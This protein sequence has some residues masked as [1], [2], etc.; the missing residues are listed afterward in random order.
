[1]LLDRSQ[2]TFVVVVFISTSSRWPMKKRQIKTMNHQKC[3]E[4]FSSRTGD[5]S[6]V[7]LNDERR[8]ITIC[9]SGIDKLVKRVLFFCGISLQNIFLAFSI[10]VSETFF[11]FQRGIDDLFVFVRDFLTSQRARGC[12]DN[13]HGHHTSMKWLQKLSSSAS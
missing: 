4:R 8:F 12:F 11:L 1:M 10:F 2:I 13:R 9:G 3:A 6:I 5:R 7:N